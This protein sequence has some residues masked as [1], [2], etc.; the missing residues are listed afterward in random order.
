VSVLGIDIGGSG[1]KGAMVNVQTGEMLTERKRIPT[2]E[3]STPEAVAAVV[4]ELARTFEAK[5]LIGVGFPAIVRH[6]VAFSAANIHESWIGTN[7]N[8]LLSKATGI[9]V[10]TVND[11]DAAGVAEM[12]FGVGKDPAN[13]KGVVI[14][15]TLGTGIGSAIFVDGVLLPNTELGHLE[16]RGKDAERRAS[17]AVRKERDLTYKK[18]AKKRLQE[19]LD[20]LDMLFSPDLL[21]IGGGV[22]KE[23]DLFLPYVKTRAKIIPA[24]LQNQAGIVGAALYASQ[25][26]A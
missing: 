19:Y 10:Y 23:A 12:R 1:I 3:Q 5:G 16:I 11:A 22:S 9:P 4:A 2:P 17:D 13:R 8:E 26:A 20:R 15:L 14:L 21:V 24:Q 7:V 25:Q 6:G 18:W